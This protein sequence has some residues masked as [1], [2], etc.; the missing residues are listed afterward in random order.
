MVPSGH[1][2]GKY[3]G[4]FGVILLRILEFGGSP[5]DGAPSH[6]VMT[7]GKRGRIRPRNQMAVLV[8]S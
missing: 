6:R 4:L 8:A 5:V 7:R 1:H 3:W 2:C